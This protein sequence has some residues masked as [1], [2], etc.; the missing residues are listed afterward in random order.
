MC[1]CQP[2]YTLGAGGKCV[3]IDECADRTSCHISAQCQNTLGSHK[4]LC[5]SGHIGD[6]YTSGCRPKGECSSNL[7]CP[8]ASACSNGRCIDPCSSE[9]GRSPCG[10]GAICSVVDHSALC[11]CP[12]R[13][14]GDPRQQCRSLECVE[15]NDCSPGN[16]QDWSL[17][18]FY[19]I[20][21]GY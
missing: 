20:L 4:C 15:N 18:Q 19:S 10:S 17:T 14:S 3:D 12:A 8:V 6:P 13:T 21:V 11:S 5:P 16:N 9:G 7:D 1:I 2:G